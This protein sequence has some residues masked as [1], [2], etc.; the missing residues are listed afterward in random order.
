MVRNTRIPAIACTCEMCHHQWHSI[1]RKIPE[2]CANLK[3]RSREWNGKKQRTAKPKVKI[4]LPKPE[5]TRIN[6]D[7]S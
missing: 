2:C 7:E 3:C 4:E 6:I 5:R 1:A